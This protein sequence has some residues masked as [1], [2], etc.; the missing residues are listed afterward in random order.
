MRIAIL[1]VTKHGKETGRRIKKALE[2]HQL[3]FFVNEKF[4]DAEA[5]AMPKPLGR[6]VG[7]LLDYDAIVFVMA[8]GI[9]VRTISKYIKDKRTDPAV[10]AVD[11]GGRFAISVLSGHFGANELARRIAEGTGATPVI[12]T[13]T[14]LQEKPSVED[15]AKRLGLEIEDFKQAK[16][17]NASRVNDERACI[18]ITNEV[19]GSKPYATLRPKNL[20]VGI[21]ARKGID[22][23]GV[24]KA[25]RYA[26]AKAGLSTKSIKALATA[27]FKTKEKGIVEASRELRVPLEGITIEEIKNIEELFD[28]SEHVREKI[29][30]GAVSEPCAVLGGNKARLIQKKVNLGGVTVAIAEDK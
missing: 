14:D 17:V 9:A 21:G 6:F 2:G 29:G 20:I 26:F 4:A 5:R 3:A 16:K 22:K 8:L 1:A 11:E 15:I 30:V 13:A 24:L 10:I 12:T 7:E 27:D 23:E 28:S 25:I 18:V 19:I